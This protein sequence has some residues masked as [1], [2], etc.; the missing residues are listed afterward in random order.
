M[1]EVS[2]VDFPANAAQDGRPL[3]QIVLTKR[4]GDGAIMDHEEKRSL[5]ER[6]GKMLGI[7][8]APVTKKEQEDDEDMTDEEKKQ[9]EELMGKVAKLELER[10]IAKAADPTAITKVKEAIA[11]APEGV[12]DELTKAA[13]AR[14]TEIAKAGQEAAYGDFRTKLPAPMQKAFDELDADGKAKFVKS[15]QDEGDPVA[16]AVDKLSKENEALQKQVAKLTRSQALAAVRDEVKDLAKADE[17]AEEV[18]KLREAG[19]EDLAKSV[20][21]RCRS[22]GKAIETSDVFKILGVNDAP[23]GSAA[24]KLDKLAKARAT[25]DKSTYEV[26][27]SKVLQENPDLYVKFEADKKGS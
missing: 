25:E 15:F 17:I 21:E 22:A 3:A 5:L 6:L 10:D 23:E 26:A 16:K 27:Y 8:H 7:E 9:R 2:A 20:I 13:D 18:L 19:H 11:K 1:E 4:C 14:E 24:E 12:R